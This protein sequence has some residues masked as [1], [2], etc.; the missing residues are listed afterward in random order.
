MGMCMESEDVAGSVAKLA[1][2]NE[3]FLSL[4]PWN[5]RPGEGGATLLRP[6][7]GFRPPQRLVKCRETSRTE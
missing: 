5:R 1:T 3:I 7:A 6:P 2:C 4:E